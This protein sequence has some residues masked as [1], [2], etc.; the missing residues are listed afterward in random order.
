MQTKIVSFYD[1][2]SHSDHR[3]TDVFDLLLTRDLSR[4]HIVDFNP[5]AGKT[6]PLLFTYEELLDIRSKDPPSDPE[7][8]VIDSRAHWAANSNAPSN[9]HNMVPFEALSLSHGRTVEE[10][11]EKWRE[12][13]LDTMQGD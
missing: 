10:F 7:L 8:R 2:L 6:D 1:H 11:A 5:Y 9:Q 12:G 3:K 4:A 13:V